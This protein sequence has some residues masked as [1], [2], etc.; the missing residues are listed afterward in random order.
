[1][2]VYSFIHLFIHLFIINSRSGD[3]GAAAAGAEAVRP[4]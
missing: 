2:F 4:R 3:P 1:M